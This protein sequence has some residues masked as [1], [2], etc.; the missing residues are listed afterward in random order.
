VTEEELVE[1]RKI[2]Q[3]EPD[4]PALRS[5]AILQSQTQYD[6]SL[7][8]LKSIRDY[9]NLPQSTVDILVEDF[10]SLWEPI[11]L[12]A[13]ETMYRY[14]DATIPWTGRVWNPNVNPIEEPQDVLDEWLNEHFSLSDLFTTQLQK[15]ITGTFLIEGDEDEDFTY[16]AFLVAINNLAMHED[17]WILTREFGDYYSVRHIDT[18]RNN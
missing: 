7:N 6:V 12:S 8:R 4:S 10:I 3:I 2:Y 18:L 13:S 16:G 5:G 17:Q 1:F 14:K 9:S 11:H 15:A